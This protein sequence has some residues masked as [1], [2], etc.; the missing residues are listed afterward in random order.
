MPVSVR[1]WLDEANLN[2]GSHHTVC[3]Q[4]IAAPCQS[5]LRGMWTGL[6][7]HA[8]VHTLKWMCT[9]WV[10]YSKSYSPPLPSTLPL[11]PLWPQ[12]FGRENQ[13]GETA[14]ISVVSDFSCLQLVFFRKHLL[15]FQIHQ[16]K[17]SATSLPGH[18]AKVTV[19]A[20]KMKS[21]DTIKPHVECVMRRLQLALWFCLKCRDT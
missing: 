20:K 10:S 16:R 1:A 5:E 3:L 9:K 14:S 17:C 2:I 18:M 7:V 4:R 19:R 6:T 8:H 12:G 11:L 15:G 13:G 21:G